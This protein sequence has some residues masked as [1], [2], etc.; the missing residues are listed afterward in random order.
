MSQS[1]IYTEI[2]N[3]FDTNY[4]G[5]TDKVYQND[6]YTPDNLTEYTRFDVLF[7]QD[8]PLDVGEKKTYRQNGLVN[9]DVFIIKDKGLN[10][11]LVIA[12]QLTTLFRNK[13]LNGILFDWPISDPVGNEE[14]SGY[15]RYN[16]QINFKKDIQEV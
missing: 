8:L 11:A 16:M 1:T 9:I 5:T 15:F 2:K 7:G 3:Y 6:T 10:D 12:D 14:G 13:N 4:T